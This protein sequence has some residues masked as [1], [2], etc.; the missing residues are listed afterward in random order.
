MHPESGPELRLHHSINDE[1]GIFV[2]QAGVRVAVHFDARYVCT[3]SLLHQI[4]DKRFA[5]SASHP[6]G[7]NEQVFEFE[8]IAT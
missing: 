3:M 7:V 2:E 4:C 8:V 1:S 5:Y 6:V